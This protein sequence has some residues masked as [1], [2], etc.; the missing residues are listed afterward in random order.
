[1]EI[2]NVSQLMD[3]MTIVCPKR[4]Q[5]KMEQHDTQPIDFTRIDMEEKKDSQQHS[6]FTEFSESVNRNC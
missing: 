2:Q 6:I 1:M 3:A 4:R 5:E